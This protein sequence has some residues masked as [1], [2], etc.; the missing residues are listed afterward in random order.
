MGGSVAVTARRANGEEFRMCR[1]TNALPAY[2]QDAR[3]IDGDESQLDEYLKP[4]LRMR[5]DFEKNFPGPQPKVNAPGDAWRK[6]GDAFEHNMTSVYAPY[7]YLAPHSYGLVVIDYKT[8]TVLSMQGYSSLIEIFPDDFPK[9][10]PAEP[11]EDL[12]ELMQMLATGRNEIDAR[13]TKLIERGSVCVMPR[14]VRSDTEAQEN[15]RR[16]PTVKAVQ[17]LL[18]SVDENGAWKE[19]FFFVNPTPWTM[20]RFPET[21]EGLAQLKEAVL[22]LGFEL[23]DHEKALWD[24]FARRWEDEDYDEEE[25]D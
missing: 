20:R 6:W 17:D 10:E 2:F 4:W 22:E 23:S 1:W 12:P 19:F 24:K 16:I 14:G 18:A 7:P 8:K 5:K 9:P 21:T 15:A 11:L 3:W 25:D 13:I